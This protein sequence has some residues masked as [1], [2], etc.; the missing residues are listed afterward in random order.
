VIGLGNDRLY[1]LV[2][3]LLLLML[4]GLSNWLLVLLLLLG[5]L[6]VRGGPLLLLL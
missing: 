4:L 2:S 1:L 6:A 3:L 5:W